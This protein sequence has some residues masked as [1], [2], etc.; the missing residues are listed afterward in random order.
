MG[1]SFIWKKSRRFFMALS[2]AFMAGLGLFPTV[3]TA[4]AA[5]DTVCAQVKIEVKQELTLERQAFDAHM[6]INNG[7]SNISLENIDIKVSFTDE[8]GTPVPAS[9]DP[10]NSEALFFIR[11]DSMENIDA[12]DGTG[13]IG[14]ATSA[15]IHWLIIPA[16]GSS[17]GLQQGKLY[18]V[19][20]KLTYTIGGEENVTEV[21]PDYIFVKPLPDLVIDYFL[22]QEVYGDDAFTPIVESPVPFSLGV[23]VKNIGSGTARNLKIDSA[24]PK[25]VENTQGL[26]L[27]FSIE[28]SEVNGSPAT[29][30]LL[31][32]FGN[33]EPAAAATARWKMTCT[34]S[35]RFISFDARVSH[36][37]ELG[38]ELTS[39]IKQENTRTHTLVRDVLVDLPGRDTVQDFLALDEDT[40]RVYETDSDDTGVSDQSGA[41]TLVITNPVGSRLRYSVTTPVTAGFMFVKLPDPSGGQKVI[42]EAL[43]SDGK[44]IRK[45]NIWLSKTR[46]GQGWDHFINLFDVNTTGV[47][48]LMLDDAT[49]MPQPPVIDFIP[50]RTGVESQ[51]LAFTVTASDPNGTV[52]EFGVEQMPSGAVLS[53]QGNGTAVF[54]WTPFVG[55]AGCYEVVFTATDGALTTSRRAALIINS[56][57]DSD[58]DGLLDTWELEKFGSL[59]RDGSGDYDGDGISDLEEFLLGSDPAIGDHAPTVPVIESPVD[60]SEVVVL[61]PQLAV[62]NSSD[63]DGG[64]LTYQFELYADPGYNEPVASEEGM[65]QGVDTTSWTVPVKLT[66][67]LCYYW[68]VRATDGYSF[69]LWVYG[70]FV[71][72]SVN[73]PPGTFFISHPRDD[74][75]V[76][77]VRPLLEVTNS[78]DPDPGFL[79]YMFEVYMDSDLTIPVASVAGI[80]A[81]AAGTTAWRLETDL[82]DGVTYYWR[83]IASDELDA[84]S[85]T[86]VGAFTVDIFHTSPSAPEILAPRAGVEIAAT[87][88]DLKVVNVSHST[89]VAYFFELDVAET[90][91]SPLKMVSGAIPASP[92]GATVWR[93]AG[94][95]DNTRYFWRVRVS[96]GPADSAWTVGDFFV[97]PVNETPPVPSVHN[98][99]ER[100]WV[101]ELTPE[102][103]VNPIIDPDGDSLTYRFEV[104]IDEDLA[105]LVHR[106]VSTERSWSVP[107]EMADNTHY[108]WRVRAEDEHGALGDW[109]IAS[110]FFVHTTGPNEPPNISILSP[111]ES[112]A[113]NAASLLIRWDDSDPDS[114]ARITLYYDNDAAGDDGILI[115]ENLPEDPDGEADSYSWDISAI[116]GTFHLYATITDEQNSTTVHGSVPVTIDRTPPEITLSP[117]GGSYPTARSVTFS[118]DEA[119]EIYY[120]LDGSEPTTAAALYSTPIE[121]AAST[122]L[123]CLAMDAA[124]NLGPALSETYTIEPQRLA[125]NVG[126][127]KG[128]VLSGVK[129]YVFTTAGSYTGKSGTTDAAGTAVFNPADF[130][131]GDYKFRLDYLGNRFWSAPFSLPEDLQTDV[132]ID[133][134]SAEVTV[135]FAGAEAVG[136]KVFLFTASGGY[137]GTYQIS[138]QHGKV[139]FILPI[140]RAYSFRTDILGSQYWSLSNT[141]VAGGVN[142]LALDAGGGRYQITLMEKAETP[143]PG[144]RLYLFNQAGSYLGQYRTTLSD[145]TVEFE[146]PAGTYKVRA[147]YL[148]YQFWSDDT[149]VT[150]DTAVDFE[151]PH[152]DVGVTVNG[153]YQGAIDPIEGIRV[154]LFT[155][156]GAYQGLYRTTDSSGRV[157]YHLPQKPYKVRADYLNRQYWS[158]AFAWDDPTL[159][160]DPV[161]PIAMA[162]ADITVSGGGFPLP[163]KPV[164]VYT[165]TGA[166]LG[167]DQITTADGKVHFR[168][169][170]GDYDFRA[171]H[172]GNRYWSGDKSLVA[173]QV[174]P[175]DI[176][177]G[178]GSFTVTVS[179]GGGVPLRGVKCYVY[180][181]QDVYLGLSGS[182][183]AEGRVAFDLADGSYR[184]RIDYLGDQFWTA[185][186]AV[187]DTLSIDLDIPHE[188]VEAVVQTGYGPPAGVRVYLFAENGAY[189]GLYRQTDLAGKAVFDLPVGCKYVFRADILNSRYWSGLAEITGGSVNTV[190]IL[191][192]GGRLRAVVLER[193]AIPMP[194]VPVYLYS[195][196]GRYLGLTLPTDAAGVAFFDV[197]GGN[198]QLRADYLGYQFWQ[199]DIAVS[200]DTDTIMTIAHNQVEVT[201]AG[202]LQDTA[203]GLA[204][205][206]VY[207][208]SPTDSYLGI[209]RTT[210]ADGKAVFDLP[211]KDYKVRVDYLGSRHFSGLFNWQNVSVAI[212]MADAAITV[213]GGGF[214]QAGQILYVYS[215]VGTYLG[216]S[217]ATDS[218]GKVTFRL[219][220]GFYNFRVD[221]QGSQFWSGLQVIET[222]CANTI[223][224]S[225]GGGSFAF[226]VEKSADLPL[227]GAKCYAFTSDGIYLGLQGATNDFGQVFF[228]LADGVVKFRV[229]HMGYQFWSEEYN[230]GTTLAGA[231]D[232]GQQDVTITIEGRYLNT[233]PL[234]GLT[235]Y[236]FT[237]AGAYLG[238]HAVSDGNGQV[239]FSLPNQD[240]QVRVDTLGNQFW[241]NVFQQAGTTITIPQG[242]AIVQVLRN[243]AAVQGAKI[244][245]F[246]NSGAYLG[247]VVTT[248]ADGRA[249]FILPSRAF[250][251]RVNEGAD[252]IWSDIVAVPAGAS[253][254]ATVDLD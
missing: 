212:P 48:S 181:A 73:E 169:P 65:P 22:P 249:G 74:V 248:E 83:A 8:D 155:E 176:P 15:D 66:E 129:V 195:T 95:T 78:R 185:A 121:I 182:T 238:Q 11:R 178:G 135:R 197:P 171:D 40:Y 154:Y 143:M 10:G 35:G 26:L 86:T 209:S 239:H 20:A 3:R 91:D 200:S 60:G 5:V 166:Y 99:G 30:S 6:R 87:D 123:K 67:N 1:K 64:S 92:G 245:L 213:T 54:S 2:A 203:Q 17:N 161:I 33:I 198:Y 219:P 13:S 184:F 160:A 7:L 63:E 12:V 180:G 102:L 159:F 44:T 118:T 163:G 232:L 88:L 53:E 247:R 153:I 119:A 158:N 80:P 70:T 221:H 9:S 28:G 216:L 94:L 43:R 188:T 16:P 207:L 211:Q 47:Y 172:Q 131:T 186:A 223:V 42:V 148:G 125:V 85:E 120:T 122:T 236:L 194:G 229:D 146:V 141:I 201:V 117:P 204:G 109:T 31:V 103:T 149:A 96:D 19:G 52:P 210:A 167:L 227:A 190:P 23:R 253:V 189:L 196:D 98:P 128:R 165:T 68:R 106:G 252:Q 142:Q 251:F 29:T 100:A 162:D 34:L 97:N 133:E 32:D 231:F 107:V 51:G 138:D 72:N 62:V 79:T 50:D 175:V 183:D 174:N 220:T 177:T 134:E 144:V 49:V 126:T 132:V 250:K 127:D 217:Q 71:V 173:H 130:T 21:T 152:R 179:R 202:L 254:E 105:N 218:D 205:L 225:V 76:D 25:I 137:L 234:E 226:A 38:G 75:L 224:I 243:G 246:D 110:P 168:L 235:V 59:S 111:V 192:G 237:P 228:D 84:R 242:Q 18:N 116:E 36:S 150:T 139:S 187:P 56:V 214:P 113:T 14:P 140:G 206:K 244:Y 114:S 222:G 215:E 81:G 69:S 157:N 45:E 136:V 101:G 164:F 241:S 61:Q 151:I 55:Q 233:A 58:G 112:V 4:A 77:T 193:D 108:F 82:A 115:A 24:Q 27:G 46:N 124:G 41:S 191:A 208:Y 104:F 199:Q 93:V 240:Y 90:F 89:A 37:D 156:A 39:L 170:E 230:T 147:D 57:L 145:G